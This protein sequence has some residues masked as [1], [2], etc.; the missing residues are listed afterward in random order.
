MAQNVT[1]TPKTTALVK[2]NELPITGF[3]DLAKAGKF[4]A[5]SGL[6]GAKNDA[7]GF[8]LAATCHQERISFLEF[9]RRYHISETGELMNRADGMLAEFRARGGR[10]KIIANSKE[11]AAAEFEFESNKIV[12]ALTMAE[13]KEAGYCFAKGGDLKMNWKRFPDAMLWARLVSRAIRQ[14]CPEAVAGT[15]TP[16]EVSDFDDRPATTAAAPRREVTVSP[17]VADAKLA[18]LKSVTP[19]PASETAPV[20]A[21][22]VDDA[23]PPAPETT[24]EPQPDAPAPAADDCS[25]CPIGTEKTKGKPWSEMDRAL[26]CKALESKNPA[27]TDGHRAAIAKE[28]ETRSER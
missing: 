7:Q 4:I 21:E 6:F 3:D 27:L 2:R 10:Y 18:A 22:I 12:Y 15:Y 9:K 26:L 20:D 17:E 25:V 28:L 16:E 5:Q 14:L 8:V 19:P 1:T 23:P 13:V 11:K 24:P